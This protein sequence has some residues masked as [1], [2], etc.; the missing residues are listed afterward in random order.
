MA[1]HPRC[2]PVGGRF[3]GMLFGDKDDLPDDHLH[4]IEVV[5]MHREPPNVG[6]VG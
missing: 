4:L 3:N 6:G 1:A 5:A 2:D